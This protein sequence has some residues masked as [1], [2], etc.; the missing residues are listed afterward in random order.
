VVTPAVAAELV[1]LSESLPA[2]RTDVRLAAVL[3]AMPLERVRMREGL[4]T[5]GTRVRLGLPVGVC[6]RHVVSQL[7][8]GGKLHTAVAAPARRPGYVRHAGGRQR[9]SRACGTQLAAMSLQ[10]LLRAE[11]LATNAAAQRLQQSHSADRQPASITGRHISHGTVGCN[12]LC[13]TQ[14]HPHVS[15]ERKRLREA[16]V[17]DEAGVGADAGVRHHVIVEMV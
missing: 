3:H 4:V 8:R 7:S 13:G 15:L 1:Q 17:A 12:A 10:R 11:Y 16:L 9:S 5:V 2:R 6:V 14:M